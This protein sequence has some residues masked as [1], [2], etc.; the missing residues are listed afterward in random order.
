MR[1]SRLLLAICVLIAIACRAPVRP[2]A[3]SSPTSPAAMPASP[4][5]AEKHSSEPYQ[6]PAV[7]IALNGHSGAAKAT[8]KV[9]FPTAGWELKSDSSRVND[10]FGVAHF[11]FNGPD[12]GDM[13]AQM[14]DEKAWTWQSAETFSR[15][16]IWVRIARRGQ[17]APDEYRLA[18]KA[19]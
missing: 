12:P 15:A 10:R 17:A 13:V 16:E 6:G 18:A 11:T 19:P 4:G 3:A 5:D 1:A 14:I 9:T 7:T 8:V 2:P